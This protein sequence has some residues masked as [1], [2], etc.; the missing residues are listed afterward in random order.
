MN[1]A[2]RRSLKSARN[3][4]VIFTQKEQLSFERKTLRAMQTSITLTQ[5]IIH[6]SCARN[7]GVVGKPS[8]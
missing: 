8:N 5:I 7:R 1:D 2:I 3:D 4:R 6:N